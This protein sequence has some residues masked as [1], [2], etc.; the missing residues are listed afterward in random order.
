MQREIIAAW[1]RWCRGLGVPDPYLL[2]A[3]PNGGRRGAAEAA[4][5]KGEGVRTG[6]PDLFLAVPRGRYHGLFLELKTEDGRI[7]K[8]QL[9]MHA[10]L[11]RQDYFVA[12]PRS[13]G[14]AFHIIETYLR[15]EKEEVRE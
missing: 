2:F 11:A 14:E 3:V 6:V 4:I 12:V 10:L 1:D 7:S 5:L 9:A 13:V 15:F 8:H